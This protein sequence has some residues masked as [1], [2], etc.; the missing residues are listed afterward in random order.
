MSVITNGVKV[1]KIFPIP[2]R[3]FVHVLMGYKLQASFCK[4]SFRG[5]L[6]PSR[7]LFTSF[8]YVV[9]RWDRF[10]GIAGGVCG[11]FSILKGSDVLRHLGSIY[12]L[13]LHFSIFP[14]THVPIS[15]FPHFPIFP[16]LNPLHLSGVTSVVTGIQDPGSNSHRLHP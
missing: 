9:G 13:S 10:Y 12:P 3:V 2:S 8:P 15:P 7:G 14:F 4:G 11:V 1:E 6:C 16:I 5:C